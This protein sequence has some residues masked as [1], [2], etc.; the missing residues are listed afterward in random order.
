MK[1]IIISFITIILLC[2]CQSQNSTPHV[3]SKKI[4]NDTK[5]FETMQNYSKVPIYEN[6]YAFDFN[7]NKIASLKFSS[8]K[9]GEEQKFLYM[10]SNMSEPDQTFIVDDFNIGVA[11]DNNMRQFTFLSTIIYEDDDSLDTLSHLDDTISLNEDFIYLLENDLTDLVKGEEICIGA[12]VRNEFK[13]A[14]IL[15]TPIAEEV[16]STL[17]EY[18]LLTVIFE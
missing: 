7:D 1:K 11:F 16:F 15:G 13:D 6:I 18:Y 8:Y 3:Q 17:G 5:V 12:I 9:D 2:G 10:L 4:N 14:D